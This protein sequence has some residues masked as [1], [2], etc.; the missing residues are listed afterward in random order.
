MAHSVEERST[1][2]RDLKGLSHLSPN[3]GIAGRMWLQCVFEA[4]AEG[5]A[6]PLN[7]LKCFTAPAVRRVFLI[8]VDCHPLC[9]LF[10]HGICLP[11]MK[12]APLFSLSW[13]GCDFNYLSPFSPLSYEYV[14]SLWS[15]CCL[16]M[17]PDTSQG[18]PSLR[19]Y[20]PPLTS[21]G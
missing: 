16:Q 19:G 9:V 6:A 10:A 17:G 1:E 12:Q 7:S 15:L 20:S 14:P 5:C 21:M 2:E 13:A 3:R 4:R 18:C 8:F 11:G